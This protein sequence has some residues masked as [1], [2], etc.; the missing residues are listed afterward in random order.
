MI[1]LQLEEQLLKPA[2]TPY[3]EVI[4]GALRK[5]KEGFERER[6]LSQMEHFD[7][8]MPTAGFVTLLVIGG[9]LAVW[10]LQAGK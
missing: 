3:E 6:E 2:T 9:A 4:Q 8:S 10:R 5:T 7:P 1:I